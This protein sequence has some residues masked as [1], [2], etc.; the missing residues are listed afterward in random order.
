MQIT[1]SSLLNRILTGLCALVIMLGFTAGSVL[2]VEVSEE[3]YKLLQKIKLE[4]AAKQKPAHAQPHT[5]EPPTGGHANLAAAATN[6]IANLVQF[7]MQNSYSPS[8]HNADGYSNVAV[9][10]PVI[11]IALPWDEVPLL[12]TRTT[13]PYISTPDLDGGIGR[14]DGFGDIVAQ[15]YFLPKLK[16]KGVAAGLGY[17]LTIPSGGDN[18]FVGSGK[19]SLGPGAV[20]LNMQTP[21]WQWGLLSYSSFSFASANSGRNSVSNVNIQ[22]ILTKH[23][24]EGWYASVPDVPQTYDFM[25][26]NWTLAIGPRV[27]KVTK[28]GKQP[29]NLFGQ[30]TWNPLDNDD[31][32]SAEW[33]F[34]VNVT[35]LFPK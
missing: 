10:Q 12:V 33:T 17:N 2:A 26:D 30:V 14:K 11:P 32:V 16:T 19:W 6:P 5:A 15:G 4:Q 13:L 27:G 34:K 29:V 20:Y 25:T 31:Q 24:S 3:D 7:Q 35:F 28:F 18:D 21:S 22:P 23:F 1:S 9:I 8:N